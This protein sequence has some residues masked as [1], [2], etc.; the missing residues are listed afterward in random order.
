LNLSDKTNAILMYEYKRAVE[1]YGP[2]FPDLNKGIQVI[3]A[4]LGEVLEAKRKG[5]INGRHG[6]IRELAHVCAVCFKLL[7]GLHHD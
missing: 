7:E 6:V 2:T 1:K 4:E 5:D 3:F